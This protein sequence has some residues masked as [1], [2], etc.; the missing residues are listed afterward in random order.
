[1]CFPPFSL[2]VQQ[3]LYKNSKDKTILIIAHRL[4]TVEKADKIVVIDHGKVLEQG[5]HQEL[6][7]QNGMY[8]KLVQ[9]QLLTVDDSTV[10]HE[11]G[12][13][14]PVCLSNHSDR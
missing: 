10:P 4:S 9:R 3:A 12:D 14:D 13:E 5:S 7:K 2:Q 11:S 8:A 1:M 6:I